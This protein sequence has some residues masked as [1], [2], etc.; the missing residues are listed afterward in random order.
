MPA[1][2]QPAAIAAVNS[3]NGGYILPN[4]AGMGQQADHWSVHTQNWA[5][6]THD[7]FNITDRLQL[8]VGA[9]YNSETKDLG[10]NLNAT[11][12]SCT[13]LQAMETATVNTFGAGVGVV[14]FLDTVANGAFSSTMNLACNPA[15]NTI[16]NGLWSGSS[17]ENFW[18]YLASL[19][20]HLNDDTMVYA[21]YS[22]GYKAGGYNVDRSGFSVLPHS[23]SS[24]SLNTGQLHFDPEFTDSYEIGIRTSPFGRGSTF[25]VTAFYEQ[26]HDYQLNAFNGFN[27]ITRNV[28]D[29]ISKGVEIEGSVRPMEG[30]SLTAGATYNDAHYDSEVRFSPLTAPAWRQR[31]RTPCSRAKN[32]SVRAEM[33]GHWRRHLRIAARQQLPRHVLPRWPLERW[34]SHPNAGARPARAH[35]Q[36]RVRGLQRP[37][38]RWPAR[39]PLVSRTVGAQLDGPV[40][41]YRRV[42]AAACRTPTWSIPSEPR[43]VGLEFRGHW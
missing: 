37:H 18:T 6:F 38:R 14:T 15:I 35:G 24:A 36:Q 10:A 7:E 9:R 41:L 2:A 28:P 4:A 27:F 1:L 5:L 32:S 11:A 39:R 29:V 31:S 3:S 33:G 20:Y 17:D 43:T 21:G 40:L 13:S 34:L 23:T 26:I 16:S 42:P 25:N 12:N 8:T 19:S 22:R 30:L